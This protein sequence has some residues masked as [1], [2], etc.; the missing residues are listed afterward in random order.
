LILRAR[1]AEHDGVRATSTVNRVVVRVH[2]ER[3]VATAADRGLDNGALGNADIVH[4]AV[5]A[6]ERPRIEIDGRGR[7]PSGEAER[8]VG[9]SIPDRNDRMRVHREIEI[10]RD[11]PPML[12]L[13]PKIWPPPASGPDVAAPQS[14][15]AASMSRIIGVVGS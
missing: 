2:N 13:K 10:A 3:V 11:Q 7:R 12:L 8:V 4:L 15:C 6:A 5:R 1:A 9:T 14:C